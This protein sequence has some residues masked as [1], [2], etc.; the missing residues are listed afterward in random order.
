MTNII[1]AAYAAERTAVKATSFVAFALLLFI[2]S[3]S[4]LC[5]PM[6][7]LIVKTS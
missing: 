4:G 1:A 6:I 5:T 2:I 7:K 3:F